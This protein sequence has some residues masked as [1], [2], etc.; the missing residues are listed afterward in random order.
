LIFNVLGLHTPNVQGMKAL[1]E[2]VFFSIY[3]P[4]LKPRFPHHFSLSNPSL[5]LKPQAPRVDESRLDDV[6]PRSVPVK[7]TS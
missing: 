5:I 4:Q 1:Q 6:V 3:F 2:S 7:W